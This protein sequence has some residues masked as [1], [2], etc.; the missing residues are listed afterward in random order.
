MSNNAWPPEYTVRKSKRA[1]RLRLTVTRRK[2]IEIVIP[3]YTPYRAA[4]TMMLEQRSWI[5][6]ELQKIQAE[7]LIDNPKKLP[8]EIYLRCIEQL[9]QVNYQAD[10]KRLRVK[11]IAPLT[12]LVSGELNISN[13][14]DILITWLKKQAKKI[15]NPW[16]HELS[17]ETNLP[18][19][20]LTIRGQTTRWGSCSSKKAINLNYKL[21]FLPDKLVEYVLLHELCHTV[22]LNHSEKFWHLM[23][24]IDDNS[25]KIDTESRKAQ[26]YVPAWVER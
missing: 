17:L 24:K 25:K 16:L 18:F 7:S 11:K 5:E 23:Q 4:E 12:L 2:G 6:Q 15:L 20:S 1:K 22:H 21:L 10:D 3:Y 14:Q 26:K 13:C 8:Q 19:T 9:W